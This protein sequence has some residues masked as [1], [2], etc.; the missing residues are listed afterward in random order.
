MYSVFGATGYVGSTFCSMYDNEVVRQGRENRV[1]RTN[2]ILYL[3]STTDNY[4]VHE[5]ITLDV[6]TNLKVLCEVL[7]YCKKEDIVFN[8]VSSWFVYGKT[9]LPATE[10]SPCN[11]TGFYSI[12][13]K[14]A[15]DLIISFCN[16]F[17]CKYRIMRLCNVVGGIDHN[18]G[19]VKSDVSRKKNAITYMINKLKN[20]Q[21]IYLYDNGTPIRD[22]MHVGD[23]CRAIHL[24]MEEGN[25]NEIYNIGSGQP[26][27]IGDIMKLA[28]EFLDS[29]GNIY[30]REAAD[31]HKVVQAKDFW[32]DTTKLKNLGFKQTI[33][34]EAI[35]KELCT[36]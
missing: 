8:F 28:K 5:N 2:D 36:N 6:E 30:G 12:T 26:T 4:N 3:I 13:K 1:P 20:D 33:P 17:G 9:K 14:A 16:T 29:K 31:F 15:E 19:V 27:Q 10:E 32:Y 24:V 7:E 23:V 18:G 25:L 11:P 35:I 34:T 22:I 21:D